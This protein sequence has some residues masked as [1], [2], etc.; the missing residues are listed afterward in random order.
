M[1]IPP[2]AKGLNNNTVG[3]WFMLTDRLTELRLRMLAGNDFGRIA[4]RPIRKQ[5]NWASG[6]GSGHAK[7]AWNKDLYTKN[8]CF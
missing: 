3:L 7:P 1:A 6:I 4:V 2:I 8:R 5:R